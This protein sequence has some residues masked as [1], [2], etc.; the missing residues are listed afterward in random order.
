MT[1]LLVEVRKRFQIGFSLREFFGASTLRQFAALI[2]QGRNRTGQGRAPVH[3]RDSEWGKQRMAFLRREAELPAGIAPAR[4]LTFQPEPQCRA[5]LLTGCTG[6][7]GAYILA[8]ALLTT[9][10]QLYCLVRPKEGAG[11]KERIEQQ[12]RRLELWRND[13]DWLSAFA[14]RVH[15][16]AGDVILPRLGLPDAS[17]EMLARN[18]DCII[19]CAAYVNFIYPYEALKATNVLGVHEIIR[20]AFHARIKPV[21]YL[22]TAAIWPMGPEY[23]FYESDAIDH[24]QL[25]NSG[26]DDVKW[27]GEKC[28]IN[29]ADRGLPVA[30]YR[31]G[32]VSGDSRTGRGMLH[33]FIVSAF[34]GFLQLGAF[35][36]IDTYLDMAPVD[37]MTK[38]LVH[39]AFRRKPLGRAF[40]LTNPRPLPMREVLTF[41][42]NLGYRF[43]EIPFAEVRRRLF[44]DADFPNNALFPFQ[45]ALESM[46]DRNFQLPHYDCRQTLA[47]LQGSG[48]VCPPVDEKLL[49]LY[50]RYLRSVG[51]LPEPAT[52][53][54]DARRTGLAM[55]IA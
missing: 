22:S 54:A 3:D 34:K 38:A 39:L 42:R 51:Y 8:E 27:V 25:L 32:E 36:R 13:Q 24:G 50:V 45:T 2:E 53:P 37:Y 4:G 11:G 55:S 49:G 46:D 29:A 12:L 48:I 9:H 19:H 21:H 20:F 15:P 23:I 5:V 43:E 26:Y 41:F 30:R 33:H 14:E 31:P 44:E 10:A 47:E 28:L 16:V 40:H 35:P 18:I 7:L 1:H 17:Y 6:F 52:P